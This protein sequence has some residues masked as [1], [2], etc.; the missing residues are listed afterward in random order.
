MSKEFFYRAHNVDRLPG[1]QGVFP[2]PFLNVDR[3][4]L[5]TD[6]GLHYIFGLWFYKRFGLNYRSSAIMATGSLDQALEFGGNII[7]IVP[8]GDFSLCY[9]IYCRDLHIETYEMAHD[10]L[11]CSKAIAE[12]F[13][14][15][16]SLNYVEH[17]NTGI[18]E[19]VESGNEV[20]ICANSFK[21]N[22]IGG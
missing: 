8:E 21:F 9:S 13:D 14:F 5:N 7:R 19:A 1:R 16:D 2:N 22:L 20:M 6:L 15:L 12:I 17:E 11:T 3:R 4:P 10:S 18:K